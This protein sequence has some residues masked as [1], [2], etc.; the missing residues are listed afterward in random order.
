MTEVGELVEI[1]RFAGRDVLLVQ[2]G[3]GN[4]S[5][6]SSDGARM[7][8]KASG[9]RL[10]EVTRDSGYVET[11]LPSLVAL[12]RHPDLTARSRSQAHEEFV[13]RLQTS[14]RP[15]LEIGFHAVL[16]RVVLHPHPVYVNAFACMEGGEAAL[17]EALSEP[18]VWVR[19]EPPGYALGAEVD[20]VAAGFQRTHGHLP[21]TIVLSNHGLIAA[22]AR[23]AEVIAATRRLV[24]AGKAHFGVVPARARAGAA[25][26]RRLVAWG[27][28]FEQVL[29][30]R[31]PGR[32]VVVRATTRVALIQA[33]REP[34]RWLTAGPLV[35]D[36][37]VY[38][39]HK[40]WRAEVTDS[41]ETWLDR[42]VRSEPAKMIVT[43][44]GLGVVFAA[45][46]HHMV[47]A[48]EE[49][50]LAHV[51]TRQLIA[52]RG[53]ARVL[54]PDEIDYLRSMESEKYR[55]AVAAGFADGAE[56]KT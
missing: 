55:E 25:P 28:R 12:M 49:N 31:A 23:G 48:M 11:D 19:Y 42:E 52:R 35:P 5:V 44:T 3:G 7:W 47:D 18:V 41:A 4:A 15:S 9:V 46:G 51:L 54:P 40:V 38:G 53:R 30:R 43:V 16:T 45:S 22:G 27:E 17:A 33:A 2:G 36:D 21:A 34:D 37:V 24:G 32:D 13:R 29:R 20:T 26:P 8:I 39:G 14:P 50:L 10:R 1:S 56:R 6:K